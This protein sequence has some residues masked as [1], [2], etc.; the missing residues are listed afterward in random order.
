M[1]EVIYKSLSTWLTDLANSLISLLKILVQSSFRLRLPARQKAVCSVLGNGP[2][3][4]TSLEKDLE[5]ILQTE[6]VCVNNFAHSPYFLQLK[7]QDYVIADPNYFV[8]TE[9][10]TDRDDIRQTLGV[11]LASVDWP[12]YLY[13]PRFAKGSY[14]MNT[15]EARNPNIKPVYFNYTVIKGFRWFR[16]RLYKAGLGIG[17]SQTVI[18]SALF[19][20]LSRQFDTIYLFGADQ[21]WHEQIRIDEQNQL[22]M[23][24]M[25]FYDKPKDVAYVPVYAD[26]HRTKTH[27]MADQFLSL[28]KAFRGY[29]VLREYADYLGVRLLNASSKSYIDALERVQ[30]KKSNAAS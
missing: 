27:S 10:T 5:F 4:N 30:L 25:H 11:F 3:L 17:Q 6:I 16:F 24:Q 14:I 13:V 21:S 9:Q 22:L 28:H 18:V 19:L 15:I 2:S 29:E 7:P 1:I 8:F 23:Q 20:M 26:K 12:M